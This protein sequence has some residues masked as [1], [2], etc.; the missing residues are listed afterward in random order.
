MSGKD[1]EFITEYKNKII[2]IKDDFIIINN[3]TYT[4]TGRIFII[5]ENDFMGN[6]ILYL[7][8]LK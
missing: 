4:V 2:P 8:L 6:I 3:K 7:Q 5:D 1:N